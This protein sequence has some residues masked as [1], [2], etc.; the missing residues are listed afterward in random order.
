[1][2]MKRTLDRI[3]GF[4]LYRIICVIAILFYGILFRRSVKGRH[5]VPRTGPLIIA[6]NHASFVD[7]PLI[8]SSIPREIYF[9]T[10]DTLMKN[11]F[12]RYLLLRL[13]CIPVDRDRGDVKALR[14]TI[15]CV[16]DGNAVLLFPEGTRTTDGN[17][18]DG[19]TGIGFIVHKTKVPVLPV[20]CDGTFDILP[21]NTKLPRLK[22]VR[23]HFGKPLIFSQLYQMKGSQEI[24]QDITD[25]IMNA[26]KA[27][28]CEKLSEQLKNVK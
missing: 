25:Q 7:P 13:N 2:K 1:M 5:H 16:S 24:Y 15:K 26:I 19:K 23:V 10:R 17:I 8:G 3:V 22:K 9:L 14:A 20:Y 27:L 6:S 11:P 21:K 18:Q 28:R 4:I 12:W